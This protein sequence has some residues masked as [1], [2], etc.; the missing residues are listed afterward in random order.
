ML[1]ATGRIATL[2]L[3]HLALALPQALG[4]A[5]L[6]G[7]A[8]QDTWIEA[9]TAR[10][11][12]LSND[13]ERPAIH[14]AR[15]LERL[16]T[17]LA[18]TTT[19]L[20]V[21]G[22]R[23]IRV[24][25]FRDLKSFRPYRPFADDRCG[26]TVGFHVSASDVELI[27]YFAPLP[28]TGMRFAAHEYLHA[29]LARSVGE[30]PVWAN[31]GIAEF[32]STFEA[33]GRTARIGYLIRNHVLSLRDEML[34]IEE[35][36]HMTTHSP[37]YREGERRGT[38]YAQ[39]WGLVHSLA[40]DTV[41]D[42]RRFGRLIAE[43]ARGGSTIDAM[44][45]IY[46]RNAPDSIMHELR[47]R[48]CI[49]VFPSMQASFSEEFEAV[50]VHTR[51]LDGVE[52]LTALGELLAHSGDTSA[53]LARDHLENAWA[54]DS[55][56]PI[57]AA[58]LGELAERRGDRREAERWFNAVSRLP[59]KAPRAWAIAGNTLAERRLRSGAPVRWPATGPDPDALEARRFL[60]QALQA[61]P[62]AAEWLLPFALTYIDDGPDSAGVQDAIGALLS[63]HGTWPRRTAVGGGLAV[64]QMRAGNRSAS[65]FQYQNIAPGPDRQFWRGVSGHLI[66][67][68]ALEEARQLVD[69]GKPAEAESMVVR[70]RRNV[71]EPG[72]GSECDGFLAWMRNARS[73][74]AV[75]TPESSQ[76][77][78]RFLGTAGSIPSGDSTDRTGGRVDGGGTAAGDDLLTRAARS[79]AE[80]DFDSAERL[81][82]HEEL[83]RP[84]GPRRARLDSLSAHARSL[85][86]L[87]AAEAL[88]RRGAISEACA[89]YG[90][91]LNDRPPAKIRREVELRNS[92][93]C[94]R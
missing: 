11:R 22:G 54:A 58:L 39:S 80:G 6:P 19:G 21:D 76:R 93:L 30:L 66:L 62:D 63:A 12:V 4:G 38:I 87:E 55:S 2:V 45:S 65:M 13:D 70:V 64:L 25:L 40:M 3:V 67:R 8:S 15:H 32:Y 27:A 24:Y 51:T 57:A 17:T 60:V 84:H 72:V 88:V 77:G 35:L 46:G 28:K 41:E 18:R 23:E 68:S 82:T 83:R 90:V 47:S 71:T 44:R 36:L 89:L 79:L 37:D 31:E 75:P 94:R 7:A 85:R 74:V 52:V 1:T 78:G 5:V 56:R 9:R 59:G 34:P 73:P 33:H 69:G 14:A 86:R 10:F 26:L 16:A 61:R 48:A 43:L 50:P 29:V 53:P 92:L 81:I 49:G 20:E 42:G 91:I